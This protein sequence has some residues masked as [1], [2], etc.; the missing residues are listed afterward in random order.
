MKHSVKRAYDTLVA[1]DFKLDHQDRKLRSD[2]WVF[3]H[4]NE[5]DQRLIL[6]FKMSDAAASKVIKH[7]EAIV[8]LA[9]TE[10]DAAENRARRE[11]AHARRE[12]AEQAKRLEATKRI[13]AQKEAAITDARRRQYVARQ[14][15]GRLT[16]D[17]RLMVL[18]DIKQEWI[19]PDRIADELCI[20]LADVRAAINGECLLAYMHPGKRILCR[21]KEVREWVKANCPAG[22]AAS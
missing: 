10:T 11:S 14:S 13:A 17:D 5:P 18:A 6:N 7:A 12:R 8:S 1:L 21:V 16:K 9:S 20:P 3:T 19:D 2:R 15:R 22:Q 4:A